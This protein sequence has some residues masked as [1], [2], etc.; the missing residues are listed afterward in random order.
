MPLPNERCDVCTN[1]RDDVELFGPY[2][3][4]IAMITDDGYV[5][6]DCESY[7]DCYGF[8]SLLIFGSGANCIYNGREWPRC[9]HF[10][11]DDYRWCRECNEEHNGFGS[12]QSV[13]I[14]PFGEP[15][16]VHVED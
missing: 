13:D 6:N 11:L 15:N 5:E 7:V 2:T 12:D 16:G 10:E 3:K 14:C 1:C 8:W 9:V 4:C